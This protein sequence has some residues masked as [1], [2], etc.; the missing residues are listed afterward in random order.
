MFTASLRVAELGAR[1]EGLRRSKAEIMEF[2][3]PTLGL[4]DSPRLGQSFFHRRSPA[5]QASGGH[6]VLR[7]EAVSQRFAANCLARFGKAPYTFARGGVISS[8]CHFSKE[9]LMDSKR[10]NRRDLLKGGAALAGGL[11]LGVPVHA[12]EHDHGAVVPGNQNASP[13]IMGSKELIEYGQ[14]SK[15]V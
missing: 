11:T 8:S 13:M 9:R 2:G 3:A 12:Q 5:W 15:Y 4:N 7:G 14:R 1:L 6:F 10:T